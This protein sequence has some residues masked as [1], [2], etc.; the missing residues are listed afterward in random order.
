MSTA[1]HATQ[2]LPHPP[3]RV[4]RALTDPERMSRWLMPTDF[5]AELGHAF[6]FDTGGWGKVQCVV[7]A[8]EPLRLLRISWKNPPLDTTVTW[9]LFPEGAGTRLEVEHAG[10]NLEDPKQRFAYEGMKGGWSGNVAER[11]AT[12]VAE[13]A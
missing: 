11:L 8:I 4:W 7:L 6:S 1:I 10:F 13:L 9:T 3:E 2:L 12:A 5:K